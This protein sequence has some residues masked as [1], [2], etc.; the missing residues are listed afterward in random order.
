MTTSTLVVAYDPKAQQ[1]ALD[2]RPPK[3]VVRVCLEH[4]QPLRECDMPMRCALGH[5]VEETSGW[6]AVDARTGKIVGHP[7][8]EAKKG[9]Y[10]QRR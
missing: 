5:P 3:K 10:P 8:G 1:S 2:D 7:A 4:Q 9:E 6:V